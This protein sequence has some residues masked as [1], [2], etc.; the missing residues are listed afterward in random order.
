M[1]KQFL[2]PHPTRQNHRPPT[3]PWRNPKVPPIVRSR[4]RV[5]TRMRLGSASA[6]RGDEVRHDVVD[7]DESAA[8]SDVERTRRGA[9]RNPR[10]TRWIPPNGRGDAS[11]VLRPWS[12]GE[13]FRFQHR[14]LDVRWCEGPTYLRMWRRSD[15][16]V[17]NE[18]ETDAQGNRP[19]I[20]RAESTPKKT[21]EW[22]QFDL[23]TDRSCHA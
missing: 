20:G 13:A 6:T 11:K 19:A 21:N 18:R 14:G 9:G 2:R 3:P 22:I 7:V 4:S 23:N 16:W 1:E 15:R 5:Q 10:G 8:R 17:R 12:E